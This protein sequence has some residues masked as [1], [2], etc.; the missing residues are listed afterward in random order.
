MTNCPLPRQAVPRRMHAR[1]RTR[2]PIQGADQN[3][4][5]ICACV[6]RT[7][8]DHGTFGLAC[9]CASRSGRRILSRQ[10]HPA[11]RERERRRRLRPRCAAVRQVFSNLPAG[12]A[13]GDRGEHARR[14]RRH[15]VELALQ[16]RAEGRHSARHGEPD[17]ADEP[18]HRA[19][20]GALRRQQVSVARQS[21]GVDRLDLHLSHLADQDV[22]G[23]AHARDRDGRV[24]AYLDPLPAAGAV[25]PALELE[26]Q[27]HPRLR[28]DPRAS[29]SSAAR[30]K[31]AP[32]T[33]RISRASRRN[34]S[35]TSG[36]SEPDQHPDR[37]CAAAAPEISRTFRP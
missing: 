33:S 11:L 35:R 1:P 5:S 21:R 24:V 17:H 16:R 23:C 31:A 14:R 10:H 29:R 27:D 8:G 32:P 9:S 19:G 18:S 3:A 22:P 26:V 25:E 6:P 12:Q 37:E 30:S 2:G 28:P 13:D 15:H 7:G 34:G 20:A 4:R 36:R